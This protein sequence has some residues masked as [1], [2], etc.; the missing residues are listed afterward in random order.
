VNGVKLFLV[1]TWTELEWSIHPRLEEWAE[2]ASYDPLRPNDSDPL[3]RTDFV[4]RGLEEL[5]RLGWKR[6]FVVGDTFGTAT[7]AR[8]AHARRDAVRGIALGHACASWDM[9]G[10]RAPVKRE[11]WAAMSQLMSQDATSFVRHGLTQITQGSYDEELAKQM[12][13]RVPAH[14]MHAAW[15][16]IGEQPEPIGELLREIDQPLLLAQHE[17]CLVFTDEGFD[18]V[19]AAFPQAA[20]VRVA[21]PPSADE[22][23]AHALREFCLPG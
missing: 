4:E 17:G 6:Y 18:D 15:A 14:C 1:P 7:A 2:V 10:E 13:E 23:F 5:D 19:V 9:E 21:R 3:T 12:V 22:E 20:T 16:M 11:L 8:I